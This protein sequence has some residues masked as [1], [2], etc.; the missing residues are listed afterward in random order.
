MEQCSRGLG[1]VGGHKGE[2]AGV[3]KAGRGFGVS[4]QLNHSP[5]QVS[6]SFGLLPLAPE[7]QFWSQIRKSP[8]KEQ[9]NPPFW[10]SVLF[11]LSRAAASS[12]RPARDPLSGQFSLVNHLQTLLTTLF[13]FFPKAVV[14]QHQYRNHLEGLLKRRALALLPGLLVRW[15]RVQ[16]RSWPC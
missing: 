9:E 6:R 10:V 8:G 12:Q 1:G 2:A 13:Q 7:K 15:S 16:P 11:P 3:L 14:V 4:H 5:V